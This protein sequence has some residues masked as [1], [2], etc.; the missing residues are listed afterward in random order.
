YGIADP[1]PYGVDEEVGTAIPAAM[2]FLGLIFVFC[3]MLV[4]GL[5][6]LP[7]FVAKFAIL[8]TAMGSA[9]TSATPAW[10]YM[11]AV[12]LSGLAAV[13]TASRIGMRLFWTHAARRVP[14]LR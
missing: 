12:I 10:L 7:G 9:E 4:A 8:A 6:P 2:A 11:A 13:V 3:V 1:D 5:P 14:R